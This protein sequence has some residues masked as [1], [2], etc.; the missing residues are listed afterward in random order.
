MVYN[1]TEYILWWWGSNVWEPTN[2]YAIDSS[3]TSIDITWTD[4]SLQTIPPSTFGK[5]VLVRKVGSAPTSPSD[6]TTVVTE[7]VMNTYQ[8]NAYTDTWLTEW[9]TYYY[10]IFSYSSDWGITYW[11]PVS[12]TPS[13]W[14]HPWVNTIAYY[15]FNN[16]LDD[17]S[18]NWHNL[19]VRSGAVTYGVE[20]SWWKYA[21]FDINTWTYAYSNFPQI[22]TT[23]ITLSYWWQPKQIFTSWNEI[24]VAYTTTSNTVVLLATNRSVSFWNLSWEITATAD[25]WYHLC[26]T[27]WWWNLTSY[28]NWVQYETGSF[29]APWTTST[30]LVINNAR[31]TN[32]SSFANNNY[33]SELI[34]EDKA[35]TAQEIADYY[36]QTKW[37]YWIS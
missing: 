27:I 22:D 25:T 21:Y 7:T 4:N 2:L 34:I 15:E 12:A 30:K 29:S 19:S 16:N 32:S 10:Q 28:I 3:N 33:V 9:T 23:A 14:W 20:A 5:S 17:S 26:V 36:N 8:N 24:S 1:W 31:D 6:W 37:D 35:R 18:W 13:S 11:T